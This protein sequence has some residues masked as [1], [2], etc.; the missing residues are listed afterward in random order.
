MAQVL[1]TKDK[2]AL[3]MEYVNADA[4][5]I[6][7]ELWISGAQNK[8][9]EAVKKGTEN[10]RNRKKKLSDARPTFKEVRKAV[11]GDVEKARKLSAK[12]HEIGEEL[13]PIRTEIKAK[14]KEIT[15]AHNVETSGIL[16]RQ[17]VIAEKNQR[18]NEIRTALGIV[19]KPK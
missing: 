18:K 4:D 14:K 17:A 2:T 16:Y 15:E 6:D 3:S 8:I 11:L 13:K 19:H 12:W 9:A 1:K 7:R 5:I 10:L